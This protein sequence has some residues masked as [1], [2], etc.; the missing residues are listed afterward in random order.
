MTQYQLNADGSA[1]VQPVGSTVLAKDSKDNAIATALAAAGTAAQR[2]YITG[3]DFSYSTG[4]TT[5]ILQLL[6]GA[7]VIFEHYVSG[8]QFINFIQP[9]KGSLGASF[10][11]VLSA[12]G[13]VGVIGKV[14][15]RG[16][17]M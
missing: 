6:D 17:L 10:S 14:D 2:Y 11:A 12:S 15:I 13:T 7:T 5:G 9:I 1:P 16:Y 3:Y 8:R 4:A